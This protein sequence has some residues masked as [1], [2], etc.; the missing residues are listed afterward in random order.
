MKVLKKLKYRK[1]TEVCWVFVAGQEIQPKY[2]DEILHFSSNF[3]S[4][5]TSRD[6]K[7]PPLSPFPLYHGSVAS[8]TP[9]ASLAD[10]FV[11]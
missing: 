3:I 8:L 6:E 9:N 11:D 1:L 5:A 7:P 10:L 4:P 2:P